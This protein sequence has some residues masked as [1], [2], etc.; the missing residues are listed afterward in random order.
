MEA[1]HGLVDPDLDGPVIDDEEF[2]SGALGR[3]GS[4]GADAEN[5]DE[6]GFKHWERK[7][8]RPR[9]FRRRDW[10]ASSGRTRREGR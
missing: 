3:R 6:S 9:G 5:H 2:G 10:F 1:P 4:E 7:G 8:V